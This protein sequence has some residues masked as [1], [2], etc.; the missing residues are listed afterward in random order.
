[1]IFS[2]NKNNSGRFQAKDYQRLGRQVV[3]MYDELKPNRSA[4]YR[5]NFIKGL[6]SGLGGVIGA[7]VGLAL[8]LWLL[9]LFGQ[10]P[11]IGHFVDT[12]RHTM[13]SR[14]K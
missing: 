5:T 11:I 13:E 7:T 4:I 8:L 10:I 14:P 9:S 6:W 12:V 3:D 2:K 1:M